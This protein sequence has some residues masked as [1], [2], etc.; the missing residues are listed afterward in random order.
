MDMALRGTP[1]T[2]AQW[3]KLRRWEKK[4][5]PVSQF[6]QQ[7][8]GRSLNQV[9][10]ALTR[11]RKKRLRRKNTDVLTSR[12]MNSAEYRFFCDF[13]RKHPQASTAQLTLSWNAGAAAHGLP[14]VSAHT[15]STIRN[16][17]SKPA[18]RIEQMRTDFHRRRRKTRADKRRSEE[19]ERKRSELLQVR[20]REARQYRK[21]HPRCVSVHCEYCAHSWPL[22]EP[23][24]R[25]LP[26]SFHGR[27]AERELLFNTSHCDVCLNTLTWLERSYRRAGEKEET[28]KLVAL[29]RQARWEIADAALE[30][31]AS[32]A[33]EEALALYED[34]EIFC[35]TCLRC[36]TQWP[37]A[38]DYW[39]PVRCASAEGAN[40]A[41]CTYCQRYYR[42]HIR[43]LQAAGLSPF[44]VQWERE[45]FM[46]AGR[47]RALTRKREAAQKTK[48]G[49]MGDGRKQCSSCLEVWPAGIQ[50]RAQYWHV[51]SYQSREGIRSCLSGSC[52][53]CISEQEAEKTWE[54]KK[55]AAWRRKS[56]KKRK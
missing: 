39:K 43:R 18:S 28:A 11:L 16:K 8:P 31:E 19:Y 49:K 22:A 40:L 38:D 25:T 52:L 23:F 26:N 21:L 51:E 4:N 6:W 41:L 53:F 55:K 1:W 47:M 10:K 56:L 44:A 37:V 3:R 17:C 24:Y 48:R 27:G 35:E 5:L 29:K 12:R 50:F 9:A 33:Y 34:T 42:R 36:G 46:H 15:V 2:P 14:T 54:R 13:L 30:E 45:E 20:R 32:T 7:F